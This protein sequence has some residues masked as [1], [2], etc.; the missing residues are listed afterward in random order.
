MTARKISIIAGRRCPQTTRQLQR[1]RT[2]DTSRV[3]L[4]LLQTLGFLHHLDRWF[5][6]S[7]PGNVLIILINA[8][9]H[10]SY[11]PQTQCPCHLSQKVSNVCVLNCV[12]YLDF[13]I[14]SLSHLWSKLFRYELSFFSFSYSL[15]SVSFIKVYLQLWSLIIILYIWIHQIGNLHLLHHIT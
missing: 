13:L 6:W 12:F 9:V 1:Q 5:C 8:I 11:T 15:P 3:I 10:E 7:W 2:V 14:L 4:M